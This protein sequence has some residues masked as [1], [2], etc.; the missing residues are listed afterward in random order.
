MA[1]DE[2]TKNRLDEFARKARLEFEAN[3]QNW[4]AKD[5]AQW[6]YRWC[7]LGR[8]NHDRLGRILIDVTGVKPGFRYTVRRD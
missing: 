4:T 6:W 5:V 7:Q 8:T 2:E 1:L 3:W